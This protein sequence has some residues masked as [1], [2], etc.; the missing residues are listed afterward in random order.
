MFRLCVVSGLLLSAAVS[1]AVTASPSDDVDK[2]KQA[3]DRV[4]KVCHGEGAQ[5]DAGP[6]LI[7]FDREY[8]DLIA[9]VR[10]GTGQMPPIAAERLSDDD[11]KA[12]VVYLKSLTAD[13]K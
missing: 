1:T 10:D 6:R 8:E 11:V 7:P 5:G 2:G 9:I 13:A 12:I 3:F 4:C